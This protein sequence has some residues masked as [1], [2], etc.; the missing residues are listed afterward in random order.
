MDGGG[1]ERSVGRE[2]G[3]REVEGERRGCSGVED[4]RLGQGFYIYIGQS[5]RPILSIP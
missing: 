3:R 4:G 5:L 1:E 2:G